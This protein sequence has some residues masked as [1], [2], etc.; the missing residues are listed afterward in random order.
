MLS[1]CTG[2]NNIFYAF[3][4]KLSCAPFLIETRALYRKKKKKKKKYA[5]LCVA[6]ERELFYGIM[7]YVDN[8][9]VWPKES[10][11]FCG[12]S[13]PPCLIQNITFNPQNINQG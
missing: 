10:R 7:F 4:S 5:S 13:L 1:F 6:S 11:F 3:L 9:V 12:R 8:E 2:T